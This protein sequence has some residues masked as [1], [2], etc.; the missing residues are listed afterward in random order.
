MYTYYSLVVSYFTTCQISDNIEFLFVFIVFEPI[1]VIN[2][3]NIYVL[4]HVS[5]CNHIVNV[6][7]LS[8]HF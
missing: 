7:L 2:R 5:S 6:F 8:H 3:V 1:V 4:Y